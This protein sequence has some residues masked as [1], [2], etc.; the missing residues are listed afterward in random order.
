MKN[1]ILPTVVLLSFGALAANGNPG[2]VDQVDDLFRCDGKAIAADRDDSPYGF[3]YHIVYSKKSDDVIRREL[4]SARAAG[5]KWIR[6]DL[7]WPW[8]PRS[9]KTGQYRFDN[10]ER[11]LRLSDEAGLR[12]LVII[13]MC[14]KNMEPLHEHLEEWTDFIRQAVTHVKGR[15]THWEIWNEENFRNERRWGSKN[16]SVHARNY[17]TCLKAAYKAVKASDPEAVVLYGGTSH[18]PLDFIEDT[19]AAG[20]GEAFDIMNVHPYNTSGLP[21]DGLA[22]GCRQLKLLM[23]KYGLAKKPVW[24]TEIGWSTSPRPSGDIYARVLPTA[25]E[26]L[27]IDT[28][29]VPLTIAEGVWS[30]VRDWTKCFPPF[31]RLNVIPGDDIANLDPVEHP[32][33]LPMS[34]EVIAHHRQEMLLDYV[35]RGGTV[36]LPRGY[37]FATVS[38]ERDA[39]GRPR[40]GRDLDLRREL[41]ICVEFP[42]TARHPYCTNIA[43]SATGPAAKDIHYRCARYLTDKWTKKGDSFTPVLWATEGA[44]RMPIAGVY[45][46]N[47]SLKGAAIVVTEPG[48]GMRTQVTEADQAR[49]IVRAHLLGLSAGYEKLIWYQFVSGSGGKQSSNLEANYG[50]AYT[51]CDGEPEK[52]AAYEAYKTLTHLMP[53][54]SVFESQAVGSQTK[55]YSVRWR[56]PDGRHVL[57]AWMKYGTADFTYPDD[58]LAV[59]DMYGHRLP[60][61]K[62]CRI[63]TDVVYCVYGGSRELP[64][65]SQMIG[66]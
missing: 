47:T 53:A 43:F 46:Y 21:E 66:E 17:A 65:Q 50:I 13:N 37:P 34:G 23:A 60:E 36:I 55:P 6:A 54:G 27:G 15:V 5:A 12:L 32:V 24:A 61:S 64:Q 33:L 57:A 45:K 7:S 20:A 18:V 22:S 38:T 63:G 3:C 10:M 25:F 48:V 9:R 31:A 2:T 28:R 51:T 56:R 30:P 16:Q 35:R 41:G 62:G 14:A 59:V 40:M 52:K 26:A 49:F 42:W 58:P 19:F 8:Q 1:L 4:A 39:E 11:S 44:F 29:K